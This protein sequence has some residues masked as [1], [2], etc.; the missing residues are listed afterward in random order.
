MKN[1]DSRFLFIQSWEPTTAASDSSHFLF[2]DS[3]IKISP[4]LELNCLND[5]KKEKEL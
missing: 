3:L 4:Y 1:S 5:L 2:I